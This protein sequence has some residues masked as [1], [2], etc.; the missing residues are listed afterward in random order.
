MRASELHDENGGNFAKWRWKRVVFGGNG[1][2]NGTP[3]SSGDGISVSDQYGISV[4]GMMCM[5]HSSNPIA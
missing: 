5:A 2:E 3:F 4:L 1:N